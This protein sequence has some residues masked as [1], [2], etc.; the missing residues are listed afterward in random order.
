MSSAIFQFYDL[1]IKQFGKYFKQLNKQ[2]QMSLGLG[3]GLI[4][5]LFKILSTGLMLISLESY[6]LMATILFVWTS[7]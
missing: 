2:L 1:T 5:Q 7:K 4:K 3:W 6:G